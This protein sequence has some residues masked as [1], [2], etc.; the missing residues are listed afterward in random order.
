M[1]LTANGSV[2]YYTFSSLNEMDVTHAV[3]TRHGGVSPQPWD[4]LNVGGT[5]GD[6]SARVKE[7]LSRSLKV[8]NREIDSVFD[9]WQVHGADVVC[10]ELPKPKS[11][12]YQK[13]DIILTNKKYLTLFMRFADC[14]PILLYDPKSSVVGIVHAGWKG[15]VKKAVSVAISTMNQ[16]YSSN[17]GDI[18]AGLGPSICKHHYEVGSDVIQDV[19]FVFGND[20][21]KILTNINGSPKN[22]K[23]EFDLWAANKMLLEQAGV[24]KIEVSNI[25][26]ACHLDD[27]YSYRQEQGR[28]GRFGVLISL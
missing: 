7:N 21:S 24:S 19:E 20:A 4:S 28:T 8:V 16:K 17:P 1:P 27:W 15:T 23:A 5:V 10:A 14:V 13:A 9:V 26:T 22:Q 2:R 25:C 3:F 18:L 12:T 6:D 11:S